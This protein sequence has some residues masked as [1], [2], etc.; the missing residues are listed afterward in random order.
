MACSASAGALALVVRLPVVSGA[1][2]CATRP[3]IMTPLLSGT[4]KLSLSVNVLV[5]LDDH[6]GVAR[7]IQVIDRPIEVHVSPSWWAADLWRKY[8]QWIISTIVGSGIIGW[9]WNRLRRRG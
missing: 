9:I 7:E 8:W 4:Q 2:G 5:R 1:L 3:A 6:P